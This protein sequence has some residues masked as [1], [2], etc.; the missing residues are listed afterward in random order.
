MSKIEK[1]PLD[2]IQEGMSRRDALK[3]MGLSPIAAGVLASSTTTTKASASEAKGKILI[4]GGGAGG[5]MAMARLRSIR[6]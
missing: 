1:N 2:I 5:I 3:F 6:S 4:V